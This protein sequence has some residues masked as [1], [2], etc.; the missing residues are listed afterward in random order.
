M[1][2]WGVSV[3]VGGCVGGGGECVGVVCVVGC[4][5]CFCGVVWVRG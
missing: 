2:V 1:Y 5:G 4:G 3:C